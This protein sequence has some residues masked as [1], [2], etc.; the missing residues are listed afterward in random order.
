MNTADILILGGG[1]AGLSTAL[2][3]TRLDPSFARRILILEKEHYPRP[4]LCAGG[5]ITD[6]EVILERLGLDVTQIPHVDVETAHFDFAGRGLKIRN[7]KGH[8]IRVIRRDEFDAWLAKNTENRGVEIREGVTVTAVLPDP[9]GVTVET[10]AGTFR[11]QIVVGADGSNGVTRRCIL[12]NEPLSTSRTLE[13]VI[14]SAAKQSPNPQRLLRRGERPPRNDIHTDAYFDFF[15]V[16]QNVA[17]YVWDFPTQVKGQPMRCWGVYDC[18]LLANFKRPALKDLLAAEMSR[19]GFNLD[20]CEIQSHPIRW[21]EPHKRI[22]VPRVLLVGDAAGVDSFFGEGLSPA[23]G[24]GAVAAQEIAE[25]FRRNEFSFGRYK[26][27]VAF[28]GL[29]QT[30]FARWLTSQIL[31]PL[32]WAWF[33]FLV[34]RILQPLVIVIAW[35]FI[36][37]WSKRLK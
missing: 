1:P 27:R 37:N 23:L 21:Y 29:G 20:D 34:W 14:A 12:P 30:L 18:N 16:P 25:S 32:K 26:N 8:S 24:Y 4:K 2:H 15:P 35:V 22:S 17:G 3:L 9:D 10:D 5:L 6:A 7:G 33:Q 13:V 31:Y 11:A 19:R 36:L 28:G